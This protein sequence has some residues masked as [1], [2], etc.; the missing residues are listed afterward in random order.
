MCVFIGI[1]SSLV[2][3]YLFRNWTFQWESDTVT[4]SMLF[5]VFLSFLLF[6]L[7]CLSFFSSSMFLLW[8]TVSRIKKTKKKVIIF[9]DD[10][11]VV[12]P[13][14]FF[15]LSLIDS[16]EHVIRSFWARQSL[17]STNQIPTQHCIQLSTDFLFLYLCYCLFLW[18]FLEI[19][20]F[21]TF[22]EW[23]TLSN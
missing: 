10:S 19:I 20:S 2:I 16:G 12:V 8:L 5:S 9:F 11:D 23:K 18:L 1:S 14:L 21:I 3:F 15:S 6:K 17:I 4:L 7:R 13:H 22:C